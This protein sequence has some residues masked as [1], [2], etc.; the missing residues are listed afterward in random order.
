MLHLWGIYESRIQ[1]K[2]II[3]F[4]SLANK[5]GKILDYIYIEFLGQEI[6]RVILDEGEKGAFR[7]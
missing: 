1:E 2:A 7:N 4:C 6:K 3:C 5:E